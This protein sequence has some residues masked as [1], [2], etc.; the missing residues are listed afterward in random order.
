VFAGVNSV[1]GKCGLLN[2]EDNKVPLAYHH[3]L[4]G[5]RQVLSC[6]RIVHITSYECQPATRIK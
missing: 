3:E 6:L 4:P 2:I 1:G 5:L